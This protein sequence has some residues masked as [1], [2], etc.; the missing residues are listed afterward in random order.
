MYG[1]DRLT[2]PMLRMKNGQYDKEGEFTPQL[3]ILPLK[4][5]RKNLSLH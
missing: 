1:K 2:H 4:Q 5:W 3:G